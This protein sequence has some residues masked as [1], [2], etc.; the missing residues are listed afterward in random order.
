MKNNI[1][2]LKMHCRCGIYMYNS[3]DL[4][5][6]LP[7]DLRHDLQYRDNISKYSP[8]LRNPWLKTDLNNNSLVINPPVILYEFLKHERNFTI[9]KN[10]TA[11]FFQTDLIIF[12]ILNPTY[13]ITSHS[14]GTILG[15]K[16]LLSSD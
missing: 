15:K 4:P 9:F 1:K 16:I 11:V 8:N 5:H 13:H 7:P 10:R 14:R 2:T 3:M 6:A 12:R